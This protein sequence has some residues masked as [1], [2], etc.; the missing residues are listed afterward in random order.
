[1]ISLKNISQKANSTIS[2]SDEIMKLK[3]LLDSGILTQ[4]EFDNKKKQLLNL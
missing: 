2:A 4:E 1:M 3:N